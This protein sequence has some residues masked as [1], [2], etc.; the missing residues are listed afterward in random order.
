[1]ILIAVEW[2]FATFLMSPAS[3]NAFFATVDFPYFAL[4]TSPT[5]RHIF[6]Q[7]ETTSGAFWRDMGLGFLASVV[8]TRI[9]IVFGE[10]MSRVKR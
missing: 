2:P 9:G 6:V 8:S 4:P 3:R 5:V 10:W 7:W 1:M